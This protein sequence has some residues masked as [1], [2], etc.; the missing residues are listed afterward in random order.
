[1]VHSDHSVQVHPVAI[2]EVRR[3][4]LE[5]LKA[6]NVCDAP[7]LDPVGDEEERASLTD[8]DADVAVQ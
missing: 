3:I 6:E 1:M 7:V 2:Y 8:A 5:H 4:L